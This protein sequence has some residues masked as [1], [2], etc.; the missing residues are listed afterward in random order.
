MTADEPIIIDA[1]GPKRSDPP[2]IAVRDFI[3]LSSAVVVKYITATDLFEETLGKVHRCLREGVELVCV[4]FGRHDTI[5]A[6]TGITK[7]QILTPD[8]EGTHDAL[9]VRYGL[10]LSE[11]LREGRAIRFAQAISS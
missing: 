7:L 2:V 3:R 6:Y 11:L 4:V 10:S 1:A 8:D 9:L 5:Y